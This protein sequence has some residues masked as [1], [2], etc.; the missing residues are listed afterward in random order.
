MFVKTVGKKVTSDLKVKAVAVANVEKRQHLELAYSLV[1]YQERLLLNRLENCLKS[2]ELSKI[3]SYLL[4]M[5]LLT[6]D[7]DLLHSQAKMRPPLLS[8]P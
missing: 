8:V 2:M 7:S 6:R 1:E 5:E 3:V 4:V